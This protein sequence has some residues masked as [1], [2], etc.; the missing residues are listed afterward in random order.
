VY[1]VK[2]VLLPLV[3]IGTQLAGNA[4]AAPTS[5]ATAS[6]SIVIA[7][8]TALDGTG[9]ELHHTRIVVQNGRIAR[10]D[11]TAV[12]VTYD[13]RGLTVMPGLIDVH[14]HIDWHFGP[15][16][17]YGESDETPSQA[18]R[19]IEENA[20]ATLMG[21]F[22]TVQSVGSPA[23]LELR[24]S[25]DRGAAPGP[26]ILTA[27]TPLVGDNVHG[28]TPDQIR[29]DVRDTKA[30]GA[31]L[32]KIF[33]SKGILGDAQP[34]LSQAQLTAACDEARKLGL[35]TL[36]HAFHAAVRMAAL[37]GCTEVEHGTYASVEDLTLL[38][39]RGVYLDPQAGLVL[40][41]YIANRE[42][43]MAAGHFNAA[44][45]PK[46]E[47][48]IPEMH[49]QFRRALAVPGLAI[50]FGSDA[51]AGAHGR[52]AEELVDRVRDCGQ[53]ATAAIV[54]ATSLAA[55]SLGLEHEIG[56][57]APGLQADIIAVQGDPLTDITAVR[58]VA[59]VMKG[60]VVYKNHGAEAPYASRIA[61]AQAHGPR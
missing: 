9:A 52:N 36:V 45:F 4:S 54:S 13:L 58:T 19:A 25:I 60:G 33:A 18:A 43:F 55:K 30:R 61:R 37:A 47:A 51:V 2:W 24:Q 29:Q 34:T 35:R 56:T 21:G 14:V 49:A 15:H 59:F 42:G 53:P 22:T 32:I 31:D 11:P 57:L 16:G 6:S 44:V 46:L 10:F 3:M 28:E 27:V 39:Q 48:V 8:D 50:V 20:R 17:G 26:R 40:E 38:A 12:P 5:E 1:P 7:V 23:D 41:N